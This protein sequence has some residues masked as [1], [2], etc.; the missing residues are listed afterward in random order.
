MI[1][2]SW[3][4]VR[5]S[6]SRTSKITSLPVFL[7]V[8]RE[9]ARADRFAKTA[10]SAT[11]SEVTR[12]FSSTPDSPLF[13][14]VF[15][16]LEVSETRKVANSST[17]ISVSA[18]G[19]RSLFSNVRNSKSYLSQTGSDPFET[20]SICRETAHSVSRRREPCRILKTGIP[21]GRMPPAALHRL[22]AGTSP[23]PQRLARRR[24]QALMVHVDV[25][26]SSSTM[27]S[28]IRS[29]SCPHCSHNVVRRSGEYDTAW[30]AHKR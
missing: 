6:R 16:A 18:L 25:S 5:R 15:A 7:P 3:A 13:L 17:S 27:R 14:R 29:C 12:P 9:G 28:I 26:Q 8:N 22:R 20:G 10:S 1:E 21:F 11:H 24:H 30:L 19:L 23:S 4:S 2:K